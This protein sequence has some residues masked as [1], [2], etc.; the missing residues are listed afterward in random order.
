MLVDEPPLP[1]DVRSLSC[2]GVASVAIGS[3]KIEP[4]GQFCDDFEF[5]WRNTGYLFLIELSLVAS[6]TKASVPT[7]TYL[8][9]PCMTTLHKPRDII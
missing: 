6:A 4:N 1:V 9:A 2:A 5:G 3:T 8:P 7:L